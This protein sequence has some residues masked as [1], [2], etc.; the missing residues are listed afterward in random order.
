GLAA[1]FDP[2]VRVAFDACIESLK[3]AGVTIIEIPLG[4]LTE[5][6]R[7]SAEGGV[8]GAEAHCLHRDNLAKSFEKYDPLVGNRLLKGADIPAHGYVGA[9]RALSDCFDRFDAEIAGFDGFLLPTVPTVPPTLTELQDEEAYLALNR[10]AF[11]LT[12]FSNRQDLP[13]IT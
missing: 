11:S 1:S 8:I 4:S 13:S 6:S 7:I 10:Q 5:G 3:A 12:E 9:L 2:A